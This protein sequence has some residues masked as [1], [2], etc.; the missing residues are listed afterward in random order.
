V[1]TTNRYSSIALNVW[2]RLLII[3][4]YEERV[5]RKMFDSAISLSRAQLGANIRADAVWT[6]DGEAIFNDKSNVAP[7][8]DGVESVLGA[9][10][11]NCFDTHRD[12]GAL[13]SVLWHSRSLFTNAK[14][15]W[16]DSCTLDSSSTSKFLPR[17]SSDGGISQENSSSIRGFE[18]RFTGI[19][20]K[21]YL[22]LLVLR[23][24]LILLLKN[25]D[26]QV[27]RGLVPSARK[28]RRI[29]HVD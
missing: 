13:K 14:R 1:T 15:R 10:D 11:T 3:V 4:F 19:G 24:S 9:L 26:L 27:V 7:R 8:V 16:A 5:R 29:D 12:G 20:H 6:D 21:S 28:R 23:R 22:T 17:A 25:R 2:A 18:S